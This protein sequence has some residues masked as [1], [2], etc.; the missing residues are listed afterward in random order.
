MAAVIKEEIKERKAQTA[1]RRPDE[2]QKR[3]LID[4]LK[5]KVAKK[6]R[7][8]KIFEEKEYLSLPKSHELY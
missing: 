7:H 3:T 8:L 2:A 6:H 4:I 5:D 1:K